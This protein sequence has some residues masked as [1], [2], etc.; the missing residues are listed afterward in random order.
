[1]VEVHIRHGQAS[2]EAR[3]GLTEEGNLQV[4]AAREYLNTNFARDFQV[5]M[6]SGSRRA[7][8]TAQLLGYANIDWLTDSRLREADWGGRGEPQDFKEWEVMSQKVAAVCREL[9][10]RYAQ[11]SRIISSHGGTLRMV[12]VAREGFE[13]ARF[14]E[15]FQEPYKYFTNCQ[16]IIYSDEN[17]NSGEI[18]TGSLWVK[19]VCP[20]DPK[21]R[22]GHDWIK[23]E[24]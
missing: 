6:H 11:Q 2:A 19:S 4:R 24:K 12:R 20:W 15:L 16:L 1:M 5:G 21:G 23:I 7:V 14:L 10:E 3:W 9:G 22:F 18:E 17:P 8:E 13:G